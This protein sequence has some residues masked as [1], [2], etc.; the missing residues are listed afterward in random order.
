MEIRKYQ[1]S[2][3]SVLA[4]LFFYTVHS[5]N[6]KDYTEEQLNAWAPR[7]MNLKGR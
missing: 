5:I 2:D 6:T 7:Q 1:Q 4:K 3:C